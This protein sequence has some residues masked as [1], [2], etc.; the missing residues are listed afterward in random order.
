VLALGLSAAHQPADSETK[1]GVIP[2]R[3]A[4]MNTITPNTTSTR[5]QV[6]R[7]IRGW[8]RPYRLGDTGMVARRA[9]PHGPE[10]GC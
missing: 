9:A 3:K 1:F 4:V 5:E 8:S 10:P 7:F 2:D 6:A